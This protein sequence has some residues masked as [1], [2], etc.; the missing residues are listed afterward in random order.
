MHQNMRPQHDG[1]AWWAWLPHWVPHCGTSSAEGQT[2]VK[3]INLQ[4]QFI[5]DV[6]IVEVFRG[7][8]RRHMGSSHIHATKIFP[9][10][11]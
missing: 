8:G 4:L 3:I 2:G 5:S 7:R 9:G 1:W 11:L 6:V 10:V